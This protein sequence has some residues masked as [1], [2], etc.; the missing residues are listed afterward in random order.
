MCI[1]DRG[2]AKDIA[3]VFFTMA[4]G[5]ACGLGYVSFA[6]VFVAVMLVVLIA[7]TVLGFADNNYDKKQLKITI[8]EDLN[9]RTVFDDSCVY[10]TDSTLHTQMYNYVYI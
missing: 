9:Y 7:A 1:R 8:P 6:A 3:V 10:E 4:A 2:N 5:L